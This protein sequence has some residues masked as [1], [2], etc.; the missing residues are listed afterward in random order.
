[1]TT[2]CLLPQRS[3]F[4]RCRILAHRKVIAQVGAQFGEAEARRVQAA[5]AIRSIVEAVVDIAQQRGFKFRVIHAPTI[6]LRACGL[7]VYKKLYSA[8]T[9]DYQA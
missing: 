2:T 4:S 7:L 1:M 8:W 6:A 9:L 3:H 5:S